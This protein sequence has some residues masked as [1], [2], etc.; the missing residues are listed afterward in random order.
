MFTY[1]YSVLR[2]ALA[3]HPHR[4]TVINLS[5]IVPY[6]PTF[7]LTHL[8]KLDTQNM[9]SIINCN[10]VLS[11]ILLNLRNDVNNKSNKSKTTGISS[12]ERQTSTHLW[13]AAE[14]RKKKSWRR[15]HFT[16]LQLHH[17]WTRMCCC[18]RTIGYSHMRNNKQWLR[19]RQLDGRFQQ[20]SN[21]HNDD[22][23]LQHG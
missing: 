21:L 11:V 23:E 14:E 13:S 2:S 10:S 7:L 16:V 5:H 18:H 19:I 6:M 4:S 22:D 15:R 12:F 9:D 17:L 1:I 3:Y 20:L 8:S